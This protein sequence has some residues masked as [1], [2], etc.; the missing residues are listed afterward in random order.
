MD[1]LFG[2]ADVRI[3]PPRAEVRAVG[4]FDIATTPTL[5]TELDDAIAAGCRDFHLDLAE[6]TFCDASTIGVLVKLQRVLLGEGSVEIGAA[7]PAVRRLLD[8]VRRAD[9]LGDPLSRAAA[10]R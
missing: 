2:V 8:L 4:E 9:L 3:N 7:S 6:V 10:A 1:H 5:T